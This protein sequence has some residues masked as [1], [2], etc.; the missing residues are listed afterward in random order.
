MI[1]LRLAK[2]LKHVRFEYLKNSRGAFG[3]NIFGLIIIYKPALR[4]KR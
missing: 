2:R 3:I 4:F 1:E